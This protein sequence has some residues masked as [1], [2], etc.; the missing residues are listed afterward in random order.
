LRVVLSR[1][2]FDS[3]YGGY[4]S[5]ILP[6]GTLVSFPIP[7]MKYS[8]SLYPKGQTPKWKTRNNENYH[9]LSYS[10]LALPFSVKQYL[11]SENLHLTT[12]RD[13]LDQLLPQGILKQNKEKYPKEFEWTCHFDPDL[14]PS[15][16]KRSTEWRGLFGQ[17]DKAELHL[18]KNHVGEDDLFLFFGWFRKTILNNNKLEY[19]SND[20]N[21]VHIIYGYL[22]IDYKISKNSKQDIVQSWMNYH[23]HF[24]SKLWDEEHNAVYVARKNLSWNDK[25]PGAG[26]FSYHPKLVLTETSRLN[27]PKNLRTFWKYD[28]FP[29]DLPITYHKRESHCIETNDQGF[30]QKYFKATARGQEFVIAQSTPILDWVYTLLKLNK[31]H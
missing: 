22:Q 26:L 20:R 2:G 30:T 27:N 18:R 28:L 10:D 15:V 7:S 4:P 23:P 9:S 21:G 1:K 6:D 12:Y 25:I 29:E 11:K 19:D 13:L 14:E 24:R 3:S 17:A 31:Y 5:P 16:L 8:S